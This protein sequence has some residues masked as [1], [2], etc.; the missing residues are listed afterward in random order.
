MATMRNKRNSMPPIGL[1]LSKYMVSN[2]ASMFEQCEET[3]QE[4]RDRSPCGALETSE[5]KLEGDKFYYR[6]I[7]LLLKMMMTNLNFPLT[8]TLLFWHSEILIS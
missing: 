6:W 3:P 7:L 5:R 8:K 2:R 1:G 4:K